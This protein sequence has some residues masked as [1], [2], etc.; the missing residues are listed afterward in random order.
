MNSPPELRL[1][2]CSHEAAE[3]ACRKWHYSGCM[4][5]GKI[6]KVGVWEAEKFIGVVLFGR[7]A[8]NHIGSKYGLEQTEVCE[9]VRIAL[10]KH[11]APVSRIAAIAM[12][13]L[14]KQSPGLRLIVSY[15]DPDR[16]HH[17]GIYQA[18]NWLYTGASE[19]QREL[20]VN[21]EPMHKR[22]AGAAYGTARPEI[23]ARMTGHDVSYGPKQWKHCYAMP[24]DEDM[25]RRV[26]KMSRPYPKASEVGHEQAPP[27]QRRRDTDP[28]APPHADQA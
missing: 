8:N 24:L 27:V 20:V 2:W 22:S 16:G 9:L 11:A 15:A 18:G 28:D 12:R 7:G 1:A 13:L 23:I 14:K 6:V 21:G 3:Y 10:T 19:A 5:A 26:L 4:P 25:R 17:G